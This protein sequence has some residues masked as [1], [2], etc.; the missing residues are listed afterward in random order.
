MRTPLCH[1]IDG[2][3]GD[4]LSSASGWKPLTNNRDQPDGRRACP[5]KRFRVRLK[6]PPQGTRLM[7]AIDPRTLM[8]TKACEL[9]DRA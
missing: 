9:I 3:Q 6:E 4:D 1:P 8:R 2:R 7:A 5:V